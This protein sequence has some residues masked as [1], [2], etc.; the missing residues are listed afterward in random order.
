MALQ[1]EVVNNLMP[2][3]RELT[4]DELQK[5][6][7]QGI[8]SSAYKGKQVTLATDDEV[9]QASKQPVQQSNEEKAVTPSMTQSA[10]ADLKAT[11]G[12]KIG[13]GAAAVGVTGL[14][15]YA[16]PWLAGPEAGIPA[17]IAMAIIGSGAALG[18]SYVGQKAQDSILSDETNAKL[19][20]GYQEA[21]AAHPLVTGATDIIGSALASGAS[22]NV[23]KS[24]SNIPKALAGDS[25]AIGK[26][27]MNAAVNP[28]INTGLQYAID[29]TLP[30]AK[31]LAAQSIAG[32][33]LFSEPAKWA[34]RLSGHGSN[35]EPSVEP[36]KD[37]TID[38]S[39]SVEQASP[40]VEGP[41]SP[42]QDKDL[43]NDNAVK[44]VY[45]KEINPKPIRGDSSYTDYA[46]AKSKYDSLRSVYVDDMRDA[47]HSK[48]LQDNPN[49]TPKSNI[50]IQPESTPTTEETKEEA[51]APTNNTSSDTPVIADNAISPDNQQNKTYYQ[52]YTDKPSSRN[53]IQSIS[54]TPEVA[55]Q[56]AEGGK[57]G[58]AG[59]KIN[60]LNASLKIFD[61]TKASPQEISNILGK[62]GVKYIEPDGHINFSGFEGSDIP[63][64]LKN[65]GYDA[66]KISEGENGTSIAVLP[67]AT[68]KLN[69]VNE[70]LTKEEQDQAQK[71][72][73]FMLPKNEEKPNT[74]IQDYQT[75][76]DTL[77]GMISEGKMGTPE[78]TSL[79]KEMEDIK[80]KYGGMPPTSSETKQLPNKNQTEEQRAQ[81]E[82]FN[83]KAWPKDIKSQSS[84][85]AESFSSY[86]RGKAEEQRLANEA[87]KLDGNPKFQS[88]IN[89]KTGRI[90]FDSQLGLLNHIKSGSATVESVLG[91]IAANK[92]SDYSELAQHYLENVPKSNLQDSIKIDPTLNGETERAN[93][94]P[95]KGIS[96]EG[97]NAIDHYSLMHE[98]GHSLLERSLP[99]E[100]T[101]YSGK[102][103]KTRMDA[104]IANEHSNPNVKELVSS[105]LEAAKNMGIEHHLFEGDN[106]TKPLAGRPDAA[107]EELGLGESG[108]AMGSFSE[109][110]TM[111]HN[112][113]EFQHMLNEMPSGLNDGKSLWSRIVTAIRKVLGI[114]VKDGSLLERALKAS[115]ELIKQPHNESSDKT[116]NTPP[117]K[118]ILL[119]TSHMGKIGKFTQSM[120]DAI[121]EIKHPIAREVADAF[122]KTLTE[123][124]QTIGQTTNKLVEA[125]KKLNLT[126]AD[127]KQLWKAADYENLNKKDGS[128]LLKT[129]AQR[130]YWRLDRQIHDLT[131]K[132][133]LASGQPVYRNG[134][135]TPLKQDPF[136]HATTMNPK[137]AEVLREN[138][139]TKAIADYQ[140]QYIDNAL[141]HGFSQKAAENAWSETRAAIQGTSK[142]EG[143]NMQF[144]NAV[145]RAQGI[146]LPESMRRSN[147]FQ[148]NEAYYNRRAT[149]RA[150]FNNVEKNPKVWAGLGNKVDAWNNKIP[151]DKTGGIAGNQAVRSQL[152]EFTGDYGGQLAHNEKALSELAT[153]LFVANPGLETH[154][155]GSNTVGTLAQADNPYQLGKQLSAILKGL[156]GGLDN[157]SK[158]AL[159]NGLL[160]PTT[161]TFADAFKTNST[162]AEKLQAIAHGWRQ[163]STL[164]GRTDKLS[165]AIMQLGTEAILPDKIE[166]ANNGDRTN[167][168]FIKKLDPSYKL[169]KTYTPEE[170]SKL[171]SVA[172][173]YIHGSHDGRTMPAWMS[174]DSEFSGFFKL[175]HWS[176][177]QT[178]KFISDVYRPATRG[179]IKPLMTNLFGSVIGGYLIK[180]IR[181]KMQG[182]TGPI[183]S[184]QDLAASEKGISGN[185]P[186]VAYN[187]IAGA[188]YA[189]FGGLL[190]QAA[191]Y[192]FDIVYKNKPQG[193]TFPLDEAA[194][195]LA[196][197]LG[198]VASAIANDPKVDYGE[199]ASHVAS[200]VLTQSVAMGR[201]GVN[202]AINSGLLT[203]TL[204]EKKQLGDKMGQ[205]RRF[206]MS[207]GLPYQ[208]QSSDESNPYMNL[209]QKK[210]K[211]TG[212]IQEAAKMIPSLVNT[213][214]TKYGSNPDV[215]L[216]K[217]KSLKGAEYNTF[218]NMDDTPLSFTKY[219]TY[220]N[221]RVG[222][223]KAQEAL[224]DYIKRKTINEVK[225]SLVP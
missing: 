123:K 183:P 202:Q 6:D 165:T 12:S 89:V 134:S 129:Q 59:A 173:T 14:A 86:E 217:L 19:R 85:L 88:P 174:G 97:N 70:P 147:F 196:Q 141:T 144:Y 185:I 79:W 120:V 210:F 67:H 108:Y 157:A 96:M 172:A 29:G 187:M 27:A 56:Y 118:K 62:E 203:G 159:D 103:L 181:E 119:E 100:L 191:K 152:K 71:D 133:Q 221:K 164:G 180:E 163:I 47:L 218:P 51:K 171:A 162:V 192:P 149:D 154:K 116:L 199:L 179:D 161:R 105:Y 20:Q 91:N 213:I 225:T 207:S 166:K 93:Y 23:F 52:S 94:N 83:R 28:A 160:K 114:K 9:S 54:E 46:L 194:T 148:N 198:N 168:Q 190:S 137:V 204:A 44:E 215:M 214:I 17:N 122:Q 35:A 73:G 117:K 7:E 220:L 178:N 31:E 74:D 8:D 60:K 21:E 40:E 101:A 131:G 37:N 90:N 34:S 195:D 124:D 63:E 169:G 33:A 211:E 22:P 150:F 206:Q 182:K 138:T 189:G 82:A 143:G 151:Q 84:T 3:T 127:S 43:I 153:S 81:Q 135:P 107:H 186:L 209:E 156:S 72:A 193:A 222:P 224:V 16:L 132:S 13:G 30:S 146:P 219:I 49:E 39:P 155:V 110:N 87:A 142:N 58:R 36:N 170:V 126:E 45:N 197:T 115:G 216:S 15:A 136:A 75:K 167:Q 80:N 145:R 102:A 42:Y 11:A 121:R 64:K 128:F 55:S 65:A 130:D 139:D 48:Y 104:Y 57:F 184:L 4:P 53:G 125:Q 98:I 66:I 38:A 2:I 177:A 68:E 92:N 223:E 158:R 140:K 212:D 18:G 188:Q 208:E 5:L 61:T 95:S 32:G 76:Y 106:A 175:A 25:Q 69:R 112:S 109:F 113:S 77:K 201:L 205:L 111:I 99:E 26:I 24:L 78:F 200:H 1:W 176:I 50:S 41:A 10:L